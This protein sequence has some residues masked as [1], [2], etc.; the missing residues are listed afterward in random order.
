MAA[1]DVLRPFLKYEDPIVTPAGAPISIVKNPSKHKHKT[2]FAVAKLNA[3]KASS[4][5]AFLAS[6][7]SE[8]VTGSQTRSSSIQGQAGSNNTVKLVTHGTSVA[9]PIGDEATTDSFVQLTPDPKV[10]LPALMKNVRDPSQILQSIFPPILLPLP[11]SSEDAVQF[12]STAKASREEVVK[13]HEE[14]LER[15]AKRFARPVGFCRIRRE[16][17]DD[18]LCELIRQ[19]TIEEP[20]RGVF[21]QRLKNEAH[22]SLKVQSDLAQRAECFS[23]RKMLSSSEGVKEMEDKVSGLQSEIAELQIKL[24]DLHQKRTAIEK[25]YDEQRQERI[26]PQQD[27]LAYWRRANHQLSLRLKAETEKEAVAGPPEEH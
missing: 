23:S 17:Y 2:P 25:K 26:K 7:E 22:K 24:H 14:L 10:M 12:V 19:L 5:E 20:A 8:P 27:E 11:E 6:R 3:A 16:I 4:R 21:L 9:A 1:V 13:L 15:L 18:V